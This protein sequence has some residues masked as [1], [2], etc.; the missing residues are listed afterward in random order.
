MPA[1]GSLLE[2]LNLGEEALYPYV[3]ERTP[4]RHLPKLPTN[5]PTAE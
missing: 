5:V 4:T 3:P 2:A 1:V